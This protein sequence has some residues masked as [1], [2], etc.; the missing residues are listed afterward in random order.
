MLP[1]EEEWSGSDGGRRRRRRRTKQ[2]PFAVSC[3]SFLSRQTRRDVPSHP[4]RVYPYCSPK[5]LSHAV[6]T[7]G[8]INTCHIGRRCRMR[9][10]VVAQSPLLLR[11]VLDGV[12]NCRRQTT[13][14][15]TR[16]DPDAALAL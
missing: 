2:E 7:T 15:R 9:R 13:D 11:R 5:C 1:G 3:A 8:T 10:L 16:D 6:K 14:R 4:G 12:D